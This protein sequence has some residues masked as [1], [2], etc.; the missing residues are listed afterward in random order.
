MQAP[1]KWYINRTDRFGNDETV[2]EQ[3]AT[4]DE[5]NE[6]TDEYR[7]SDP[8]GSYTFDRFPRPGW[9]DE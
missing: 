8:E 7:F 2:D 3:V 9:E 6:L 4:L 1:S 5:V